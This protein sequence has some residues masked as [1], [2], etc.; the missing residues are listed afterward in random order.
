[1]SD[2]HLLFFYWSIFIGC[3]NI[4]GCLYLQ[5]II[6][7][8]KFLFAIFQAMGPSKWEIGRETEEGIWDTGQFL[9]TETH[10]M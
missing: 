9:V 10:R 6:N 8:N 4:T 5:L 7:T 2:F 1:M 3:L